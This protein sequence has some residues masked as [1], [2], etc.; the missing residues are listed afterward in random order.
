MSK[1]GSGSVDTEA[2]EEVEREKA[3]FMETSEDTLDEQMT[4][5]RDAMFCPIL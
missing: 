1:I 3:Q 4:V 5:E 2:Q